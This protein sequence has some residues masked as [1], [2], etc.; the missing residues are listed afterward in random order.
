MADDHSESDGLKRAQETAIHFGGEWEW[1]AIPELLPEP[2]PEPTPEP[3]P[4]E[5]SEPSSSPR[6][7]PTVPPSPL[8]PAPPTPVSRLRFGQP[9]P[10]SDTPPPSPEA[11]IEAM[12]FIGG[13]PLTTEKA[14]SAIRG[15]TP[16]AFWDCVNGLIRK[17]RRQRRPYTIRHQDDGYTLVIRPEFRSLKERLHAGPRE[18][19]LTQP[20]LD[21]LSLVAYRQPIA[22]ADLDALR[23]ADS[24]SL[25]RLLVRLGLITSSRQPR[26]EDD[27]AVTIAY[28]TTPRFLELFHLTSLGDLPHLGDA[29]LG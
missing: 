9:P 17:Y 21:V 23:G 29:Q 24:A 1:D 25:L 13:P 20:A 8:P 3:Q 22:K 4:D 28:S 18:A 11:I 15:L 10:P 6:L 14:C 7:S 2:E 16:E 12:L 26:S 5:V 27:S 19:R